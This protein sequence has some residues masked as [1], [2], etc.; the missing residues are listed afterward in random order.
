MVRSLLF[1]FL[2]I[3]LLAQNSTDSQFTFSTEHGNMVINLHDQCSAHTDK[4]RSINKSSSVCAPRWE[5]SEGGT[6]HGYYNKEGKLSA[7]ITCDCSCMGQ[8]WTFFL[9]E[10][11]ELLLVVEHNYFYGEDGITST[12]DTWTGESLTGCFNNGML[13]FLSMPGDCGA[14]PSDDLF[15]SFQEEFEFLFV[16]AKAGLPI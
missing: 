5:S 10:E 12:P 9:F 7:I 16:Y 11:S 15:E 8:V 14:P 4:L 3:S 1:F 6:V 13:T 2:P